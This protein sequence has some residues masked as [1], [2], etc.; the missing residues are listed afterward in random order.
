MVRY[1]KPSLIRKV[2][3]VDGHAFVLRMDDSGVSVNWL[4]YFSG[5]NSL[6]SIDRIR[7][8]IRLE[9]RKNG[10]FAKIERG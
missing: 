7:K 5:L 10:R 4:E 1:I 8:L 6:E 3:T 2:G 9:L